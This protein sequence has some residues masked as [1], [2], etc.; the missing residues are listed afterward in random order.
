[1]RVLSIVSFIR[2]AERMYISSYIIL[3]ISNRIITDVEV[4]K[5][6]YR[7]PYSGG[8]EEEDSGGDEEEEEES[9]T[10]TIVQ[11]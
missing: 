3:Y 9:T 2:I 6:H 1:M 4:T 10:S 11:P 5:F 7:N 8:D